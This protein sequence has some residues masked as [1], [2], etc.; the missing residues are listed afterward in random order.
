[1]PD[2][3]VTNPTMKGPRFNAY[4]LH[5]VKQD[6]QVAEKLRSE[7]IYGRKCNYYLAILA[8]IRCS[9]IIATIQ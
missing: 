7:W 9:G 8:G 3:S 5:S 6:S 4:L 2:P 1:M